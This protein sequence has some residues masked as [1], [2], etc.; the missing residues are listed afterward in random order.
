ME[1]EPTFTIIYANHSATYYKMSEHWYMVS[2][3]TAKMRY[4]MIFILCLVQF[5]VQAS[6]WLNRTVRVDLI[7]RRQNFVRHYESERSEQKMI[8]STDIIA[9]N[10]QYPWTIKTTAWAIQGE[11]GTGVVCAG[12]LINNNFVLSILRC[13]GQK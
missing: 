9:T 8:H 6:D 2:Y 4:L 11:L 12:T 1:V 7:T 10:G 13:A 3:F 5:E